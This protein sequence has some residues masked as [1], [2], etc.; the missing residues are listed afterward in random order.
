MNIPI[1]Q[2]RVDGMKHEVYTALTNYQAE[3]DKYVQEAIDKVCSPQNIR[4]VIEKTVYDEMNT[5]IQEAAKTFYKYGEGN[6]IVSQLVIDRL[7][8][9]HGL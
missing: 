7:K 6:K 5:A 9:E 4:S 1:I 8:K 2:L 3:M